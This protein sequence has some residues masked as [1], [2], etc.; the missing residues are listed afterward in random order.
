M[1]RITGR[2]CII[3]DGYVTLLPA[4]LFQIVRAKCDEADVFS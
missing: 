4:R 2:R 1:R 3:V